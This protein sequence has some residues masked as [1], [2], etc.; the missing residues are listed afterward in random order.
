MKVIIKN[1]NQQS[2]PAACKKCNQQIIL[3][4]N[5]VTNV[6]LSQNYLEIFIFQELQNLV[7]LHPKIRFLQTKGN[8]VIVTVKVI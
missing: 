1:A 5:L 2:K 4:N 7:L 3:F 8:K 6:T